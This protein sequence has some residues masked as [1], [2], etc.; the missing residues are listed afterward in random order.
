[1]NEENKAALV[2]GASNGIGLELAKCLLNEGWTV[3]GTGRDIAS[4]ENTKKLFPRF[5]PIQADFTSNEDIERVAKII[6]DS[7]LSLHLSVQNAGMKSP[8]RP[9]TQY[10][11]ESI[12]EVFHVNLLAP[13]KLIAL[14]AAKMPPES[15]I[16]FVTSRAANLKL[17][18]SSTYCA[19]KAGLDEVTA[20]LRQELEDKNIGVSCVI[21]GEVDTK[22][23][24]I[25]RET[26]SFHLHE[27]FDQAYQMGRLIS[28]KTCAGFLK[29]FLCDLS[30]NEFKQSN[31][32]ISIYDEWH[33]SFWLNDI[34]QLPQFPF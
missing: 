7:G 10:N 33:H 19:S 16:L 29:W 1:M 3:F 17:K 13:M 31:M 30:F 23:Q 15:R 27:K 24:K 21:P 14:L 34:N 8:P 5:I 11:C 2:T 9:L 20:I 12:D 6:I 25:L 4:L 32:P 28:P 26:T 22:I 18:E